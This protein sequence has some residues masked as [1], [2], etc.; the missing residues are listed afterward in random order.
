MLPTLQ[1]C[2][3]LG[4]ACGS[5]NVPSEVEGSIYVDTPVSELDRSTFTVCKNGQ[6]VSSTLEVAG[7]GSA[8]TAECV[9]PPSVPITCDVNSSR[10][11]AVVSVHYSL[12]AT[13]TNDG[14]VY[15]LTIQQVGA[16]SPVLSATRTAHYNTSEPNGE[17][18][19]MV[20][21]GTI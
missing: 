7:S 2:A 10:A 5:V 20:T 18:C 11:G 15:T 12:N 14:D 4:H 3:G 21:T 6:C 1:A 8:A 9:Q 13:T 16:P 19:G 17:G